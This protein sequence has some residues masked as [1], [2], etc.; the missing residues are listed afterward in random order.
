M[1]SFTRLAAAAVFC[2]FASSGCRSATVHG[3]DVTMW[4]KPI[5]T[6]PGFGEVQEAAEQFKNK[7]ANFHFPERVQRLYED[8]RPVIALLT[9]ANETD[10][11]FN[12]DILTD[13]VRE[14]VTDSQKAVF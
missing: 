4:E 14:I 11:H 9:V 12:V 5:D 3:G 6:E 10:D 13:K 1:R 8:G 2:V 7:L